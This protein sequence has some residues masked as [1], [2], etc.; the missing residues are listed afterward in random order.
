MYNLFILLFNNI[1]KLNLKYYLFIFV[2][3]FFYIFINKFKYQLLEL[4][5]NLTNFKN[6]F[7]YNN[8]YLFKTN[9]SF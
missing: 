7:I 4:L 8:Y 5:H 6:I 2:N 3:I 9:L 1:T